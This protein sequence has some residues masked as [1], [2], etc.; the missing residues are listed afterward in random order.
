VIDAEGT[1]ITWTTDVMVAQVI[2]ELMNAYT[3]NQQEGL[4]R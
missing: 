3:N 1:A 2:C 4:G